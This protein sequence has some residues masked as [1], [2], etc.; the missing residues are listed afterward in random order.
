MCAWQMNS[1]GKK[2]NLSQA[3]KNGRAKKAGAPSKTD[4]KQTAVGLIPYWDNTK[5]QKETCFEQRKKQS[6]DNNSSAVQ[7]P[8]EG[9]KNN[10]VPSR[11]G[12]QKH[13]HLKKIRSQVNWD[14]RVGK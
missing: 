1:T 14:V 7:Q 3:L 11:P 5:K 8:I 2:P 13:R 12:K 9:R 6:E 4:H 10:S